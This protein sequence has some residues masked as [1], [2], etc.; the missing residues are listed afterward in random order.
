MKSYVNKMGTNRAFFFDAYGAIP[1]GFAVRG[2]GTI[3]LQEGFSI[4][5]CATI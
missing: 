3:K 2:S 4:H 5:R 1:V